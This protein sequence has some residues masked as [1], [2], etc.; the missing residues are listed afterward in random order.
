MTSHDLKSIFWTKSSYNH[1]A[2][3]FHP[4]HKHDLNVLA[5]VF[6]T[7]LGVW[8]AIQM[9]LTLNV[10]AVPVVYLY[11][12][13]I[14]MTTPV[15]TAVLHTAFVYTCLQLPIMEVMDMDMFSIPVVEYISVSPLTVC[16]LTIAAGY[17]LQDLAHWL[18]DEKTMM[19]SYIHTNPST[20]IVHTLWLMP[21]VIDS[22]L[23]RHLFISKLFVSR[24]R[25]IFCK[26][27]S[28]KAVEH[29]REW[30]NQEVPETPVSL[31]FFT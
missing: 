27:A 20:L 19:S 12:A 31:T 18:C 24:N 15:V 30:I 10:N 28:R 16:A 6:T 1:F 25:N 4:Y 8:G 14:A 17:G 9:A 13:V 21:L 7:G 26:V 5:H 11:A 2:R 3:S 23:M 22:I 29:L